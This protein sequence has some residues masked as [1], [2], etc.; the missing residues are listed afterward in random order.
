MNKTIFSD[1]WNYCTD[2]CSNFHHSSMFAGA[3]DG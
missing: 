2:L 1:Y 3:V